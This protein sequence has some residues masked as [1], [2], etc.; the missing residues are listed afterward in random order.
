MSAASDY[1]RSTKTV[2]PQLVEA[3]RDSRENLWMYEPIEPLARGAI[4]NTTAATWDDRVNRPPIDVGPY[5]A[6]SA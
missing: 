4:E 5:S 2:S 3:R 6:A 1:D